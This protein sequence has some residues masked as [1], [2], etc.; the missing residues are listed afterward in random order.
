M[1]TNSSPDNHFLKSL[2]S[3]LKDFVSEIVLFVENAKILATKR[4]DYQFIV[5][6]SERRNLPKQYHVEKTVGHL[7]IKKTSGRLAR[8]CTSVYCGL[9][10][11]L[12]NKE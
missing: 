8:R 10:I 3:E 9:R 1:K 12:Q 4:M 5:P 2:V 6:Y 11:M 7:G